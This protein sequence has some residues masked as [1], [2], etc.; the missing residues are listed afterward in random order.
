MTPI[1]KP[2]DLIFSFKFLPEKSV[3]WPNMGLVFFFYIMCGLISVFYVNINK[4]SITYISARMLLKCIVEG[5]AGTLMLPVE[6]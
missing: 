5:F 4:K 6:L 3:I 2:M 1:A